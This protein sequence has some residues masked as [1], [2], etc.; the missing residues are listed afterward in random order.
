MN[1]ISAQG[2]GVISAKDGIVSD[3]NLALIGNCHIG[4]LINAAGEIVWG[5]SL[6]HI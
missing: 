3:L 2:T 6:I 5:L 4:A 1:D